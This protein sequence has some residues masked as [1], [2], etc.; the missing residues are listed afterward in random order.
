MAKESRLAEIFRQELKKDKGLMAAFLTGAGERAKE[1]SDI[2]NYLPKSGITGAIT[3]RM[4]GKPYRAGSKNSKVERTSDISSSKYIPGMAKDMNLMRL[5]MQ[6][7]VTIWGGKPSKSVSSNMLKGK[8]TKI[9]EDSGSSGGSI[10]GGL[11]GGLGSL[12][13]GLMSVSGSIISGIAGLLG[14]VG[15]GIFSIVGGALSAM[16]PIGLLLAAGAGYLIYQLSKSINFESLGKGISDS[17]KGLG[18]GASNIAGKADNLFGTTI[19][20]EMVDYVKDAFDK[21]NI[22]AESFFDHGKLYF[23][24]MLKEVA[25]MAA[26]VAAAMLGM[27]AANI[28]SGMGGRRGVAGIPAAPAPAASAPV[29]KGGRQISALMRRPAQSAAGTAASLAAKGAGR[30]LWS[31]LG[32]IGVAISAGLITYDV[33]Q[34]LMD[35]DDKDLKELLDGGDI[36]EEQYNAVKD[37]K[38]AIK[39]INESQKSINVH[40]DYIAKLEKIGQAATLTSVQQR[41]LENAKFNKTTAE[42]T[43]AAAEKRYTEI[44]KTLGT[45]PNGSNQNLVSSGRHKTIDDKRNARLAAV[46]RNAASRVYS[47][48]TNDSLLELIKKG[49]S[50]GNYNIVNN[51]TAGVSKIIDDLTGMTV[52]EVLRQQSQG[53]FFAAGAYQV[54]PKTLAGLLANK[55]IS[56]DDIFNKETQDKIG[57]YLA[58]RRIAGAGDDPIAQQLALAK[59]WAAL[60]VPAGMALKNGQISTGSES[61]YSGSAGNKASISSANIQAALGKRIEQISPPKTKEEETKVASYYDQMV[62]LLSALIETTSG[63]TAAVGAAANATQKSNTKMESPYNDELY[64]L[65]LQMHASD[66]ASE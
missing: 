62:A 63:T 58:Q 53:K 20:R 43:L 1:K 45:N 55:V 31:V 34:Y 49:E 28:L 30:V 59:E 39:A 15:G 3:E 51:G 60:P 42:G 9:K 10:L 4:F 18:A 52:N 44:Q 21:F 6:K 38:D 54:I 46:D 37:A 64:P 25:A 50:G 22:Y 66:L 7:M 11:L 40:S 5:N 35:F 56:G 65:L 36:T 32:P 12:G 16:G 47:T 13:G 48:N 19:F 17:F 26:G 14:S 8:E 33:I 27:G 29:G 24:E 41:E 2:R 61:F 57:T 23:E